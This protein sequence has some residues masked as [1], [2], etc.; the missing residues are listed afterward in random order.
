MPPGTTHTV[1]VRWPNQTRTDTFPLCFS[2]ERPR[3][4]GFST[5]PTN[6]VFKS[7]LLGTVSTDPI[8]SRNHSGSSAATQ[9]QALQGWLQT[10]QPGA[11]GRRTVDIDAH[12]SYEGEDEKGESNS[13]LSQRRLEV[14]RGVL[15]R[16]DPQVMIGNGGIF[17]GHTEAKT[18]GRVSQPRDNPDG[19]PNLDRVAR[20]RGQ[21]AGQ[22]ITITGTIRRDAGPPATEPP[23]PT[24]P[25]STA[26][27]S[28]G[29]PGP[30][31]PPHTA[32]PPAT[33]TPGGTSPPGGT[34]T[35]ATQQPGQISGN[36]SVALRLKFVHQEELKTLTFEYNRQDATQR[37]YNPQGFF[38]LML[39]N[40]TDAEK[41]FIEVDLD[42]PFFRVLTIN[43]SMP[44]DFA[45]VG[46][47][48][49]QVAVD[50]GNPA[51]PQNHRTGDVVFS[52]ADPSDK[53][54]EFFLNQQRELNYR[55]SIDFHFDPQSS[56]SAEKFS[57]RLGPFTT[58]DRTLFIN[59]YERLGFLEVTLF[60]HE[61]DAAVVDSI[62][63]AIRPL[64]PDQTPAGP[65]KIFHV[66]PD[67]PEQFYRFRSED[68][69]VRTYSYQTTTHLKDGTVRRS[70]PKISG[71]SQL[72]VNDPFD[73]ALA[74][75]LVPLYDVNAVKTVFIDIEYDDNPNQYHRRERVTM[76]GNALRSTLRLALMNK[77]IRNYRFRLT[78]IGTNNQ[79]QSGA[80]KDTNETILAISPGP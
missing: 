3:A 58:D 14:A 64:K 30:T 76:E 10:V 79:I 71:A 2:Y 13:N 57:Y 59:P 4:E 33:E 28:T 72:P 36:P 66:L 19:S 34:S 68:P 54:L 27:P 41:T 16:L 42:D 55:Y 46:L 47:K 77:A 50:Y 6:P 23:G 37:A 38:D 5:A 45:R 21:V 69:D 8:Y 32:P 12:A 9:V 31:E 56:W 40:L 52:P 39:Q 11:N 35:P 17:L 1:T 25:P 18:A 62:D 44:I 43:A 73:D 48:S 63:V 20:I 65:E 49:A 74:I 22:N 51:D 29:P 80:F 70:E 15:R 61:I 7:Y 26:P 24:T 78:F 75:E 53:K 60:P 67:S